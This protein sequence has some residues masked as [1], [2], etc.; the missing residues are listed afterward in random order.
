LNREQW[1][2]TFQETIEKLK[3][4]GQNV[5]SYATVLEERTRLLEADWNRDKVESNSHSY[6]T[7]PYVQ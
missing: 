2:K 3:D 6:G 4:A 5:S 1:L 7:L